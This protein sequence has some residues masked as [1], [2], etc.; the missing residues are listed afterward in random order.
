MAEARAVVKRALVK[1]PAKQAPEQAP[2]QPGAFTAP[3]PV[4]TGG[5][6][7][8]PGKVFV[9][10]APRG[11]GWTAASGIPAVPG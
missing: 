4:Y 2:E 6:Y 9:T 8:E 10:D 11:I 1:A 5:T 3:H 7:Y